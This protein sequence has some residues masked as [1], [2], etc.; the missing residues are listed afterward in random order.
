MM[1]E[2]VDKLDVDF[3]EPIIVNAKSLFGASDK[4]LNELEEQIKDELLV[5]GIIEYRDEVIFT[6]TRIDFFGAGV[7][8]GTLR[9]RGGRK[10][11]VENIEFDFVVSTTASEITHG[12]AR[13]NAFFEERVYEVEGKSKNEKDVIYIGKVKG[14]VLW[15]KSDFI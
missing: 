11:K 10:M 5:E 8:G 14:V 4:L 9:T 3:E 12:L 6:D 13:T 2:I 1:E 15:L 7:F